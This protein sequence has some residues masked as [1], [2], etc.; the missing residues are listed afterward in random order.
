MTLMILSKRL[1]NVELKTSLKL[2]LCILLI[3]M[4]GKI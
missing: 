1:V 2:K 3:F 4:H